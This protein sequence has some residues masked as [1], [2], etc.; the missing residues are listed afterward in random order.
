MAD[1]IAKRRGRPPAPVDPH[2][3]GG[4]LRALREGHGLS[5]DELAAALAVDRSM[6][7]KYEDGRHDMGPAILERAARRFDVTPSYVLFGEAVIFARR[8][9]PLIGRVGAGARIEAIEV[10]AGAVDL[11]G[12]MADAS[13]FR[14][15]GDSCLPVF[16]PGDIV[17]V[18]GE[19]RLERGEFLNRFCVVETEGL[20]FLKRVES[21]VTVPGWGRT[22]DLVSPNADTLHNCRLQSARPVVLRL[23][24]G[25]R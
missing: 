7:S 18:R 13:A 12:D 15:D 10:D 19:P 1:V 8:T 16:E 24:K 2:T 23:L 4:R 6:V 11:P 5:Q 3:P 17:V 9:A 21:G 20:G 22:Y 25:R 14:V